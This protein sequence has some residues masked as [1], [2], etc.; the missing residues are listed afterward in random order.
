MPNDIAIIIKIS[1][2]YPDSAWMKS[3]VR[4]VNEVINLLND[5]PRLGQFHL[6]QLH[7]SEQCVIHGHGNAKLRTA[8]G[9][10]AIVCIDLCRLSAIQILRG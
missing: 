4:E 3:R 1:F 6:S 9:N 2:R 10:V 5:V 8:T 7:Q